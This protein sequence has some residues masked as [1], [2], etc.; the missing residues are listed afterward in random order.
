MGKAG[1]NGGRGYAC[2]WG[3]GGVEDEFAEGFAG[4]LVDHSDME[5]LDQQ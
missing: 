2:R 3:A 4:L 1:S 5:V